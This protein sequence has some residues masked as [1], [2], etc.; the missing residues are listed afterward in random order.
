MDNIL[1]E[2]T[3]ISID[4]SIYGEGINERFEAIDHNF[5]RIV[6][7]DY[8]TGKTGN[9]TGVTVCLIEDGQDYN[10]IYWPNG[11]KITQGDLRTAICNAIESV[12]TE[13]QLKSINGIGWD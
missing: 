2:I 12:A 3:S 13:T 4:N 11:K 10:G 7:T 6:G 1:K 9:N 8:L 5:K